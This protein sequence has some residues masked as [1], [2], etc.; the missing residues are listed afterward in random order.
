MFSI[1]S[2]CQ[3]LHT[4]SALAGVLVGSVCALGAIFAR[5]AGALVDVYLAEVSSEA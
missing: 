5:R 2:F 4:F 1:L 3:R